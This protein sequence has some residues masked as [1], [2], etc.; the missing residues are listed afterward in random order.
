MHEG[1]FYQRPALPHTGDE[2]CDF[3]EAIVQHWRDVLTANTTEVEFKQ[4]SEGG[5]RTVT[6]VSVFIYFSSY[7]LFCKII[8]RCK[9]EVR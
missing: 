3:C 5:T 6:L 8:A 9:E 2:V 1:E 7:K 4:V